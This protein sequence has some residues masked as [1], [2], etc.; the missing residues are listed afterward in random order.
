M[1]QLE[2]VLRGTKQEEATGQTASHQLA[3]DTDTTRIWAACCLG[4]F[5]CLRASEFT[6]WSDSEFDD[7]VHLSWGDISVG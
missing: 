2:Y 1:K 3:Q 4:F 6:V 5:A 7:E